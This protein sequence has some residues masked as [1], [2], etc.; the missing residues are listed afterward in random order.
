[1]FVKNI[2]KIVLGIDYGETNIGLAFGRNGFVA[3][4]KVISAKNEMTAIHE[5]IEAAIINK[6]T[7]FVM[8][9]PLSFDRRETFQSK[10]VRIFAKK[11]K[12]LSKMP[13][14][15]IDEFKSSKEG[16]ESALREGGTKKS[17]FL[18]DQY[19]AGIILKNYFSNL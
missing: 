14:E 6:V 3:P 17:R 8:G 9:L 1:M 12:I 15:F 11:L 19:S 2:E 16:L 7:L 13:V 4:L 5:I 10:K 18:T